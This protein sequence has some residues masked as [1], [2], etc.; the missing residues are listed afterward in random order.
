MILRII[1]YFRSS[2]QLPFTDRRMSQTSKHILLGLDAPRL[3]QLYFLGHDAMTISISILL[4][5]ACA[6]LQRT[7]YH[8]VSVDHLKPERLFWR[9]SMCADINPM[10]FFG[11]KRCE[12]IDPGC[13]LY[14]WIMIRRADY[15]AFSV[16]RPLLE[17][18]SR[19]RST[20]FDTDRFAVSSC[21]MRWRDRP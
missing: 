9:S 15:Y 16:S 13:F 7:G 12:D 11:A 6:N 19:R 14:V 21:T 8:I 4:E 17:N 5:C 3:A 20:Y 2:H 18:L 10:L 1:I